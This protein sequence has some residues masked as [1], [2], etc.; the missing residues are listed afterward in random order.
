MD[1]WKR[2][3]ETSLPNKKEFYSSVS[4]GDITSTIIGTQ[5]QIQR[6]QNE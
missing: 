5:K 2:F 4:M 1:S 6:I 3:D